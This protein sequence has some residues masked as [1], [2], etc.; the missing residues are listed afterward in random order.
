MKWKR[1]ENMSLSLSKFKD[2]KKTRQK[3]KVLWKE[4]HSMPKS[5]AEEVLFH[6]HTQEFEILLECQS[7]PQVAISTVRLYAIKN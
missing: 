2:P 7:I 4:N 3:E 5:F 1:K 6:H